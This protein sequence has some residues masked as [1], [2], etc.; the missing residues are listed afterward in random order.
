MKSVLPPEL[1]MKRLTIARI[2]NRLVLSFLA[3]LILVV[4][5]SLAVVPRPWAVPVVVVAFL[6]VIVAEFWLIHRI[7]QYDNI[8][9]RRY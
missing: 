8:R 9:C 3:P 7:V 6:S 2:H 4:P 1:E 5:L